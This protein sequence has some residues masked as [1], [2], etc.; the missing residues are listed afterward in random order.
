M[1]TQYQRETGA[2]SRV[3]HFL[4]ST[5]RDAGISTGSREPW[6]CVNKQVNHTKW[7][8][9]QGDDGLES[10]FDRRLLHRR[11]TGGP[12]QSPFRVYAR[13]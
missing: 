12:L 2:L 10:H 11:S 5:Q 3:A 4:R 13:R 6:Q 9:A 8:R 7:V 1:R